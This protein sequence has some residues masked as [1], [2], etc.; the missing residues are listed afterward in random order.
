MGISPVCFEMSSNK[1]GGLRNQTP[2]KDSDG[3][4]SGVRCF[5]ADLGKETFLCE[6]AYT[7]RYLHY[8]YRYLH[9]CEGTT[10]ICPHIYTDG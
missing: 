3:G 4:F 5:S 1:D 8:T 2:A 6:G 7:Y 10:L 9:L